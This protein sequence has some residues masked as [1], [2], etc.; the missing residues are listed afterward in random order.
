MSYLQIWFALLL[1]HLMQ[2]MALSHY[3]YCTIKEQEFYDHNE[4]KYILYFISNCPGSSNQIFLQYSA[5]LV[6][7]SAGDKNHPSF[8]IAVLGRIDKK[9]NVHSIKKKIWTR[10][11]GVFF[12][13]G[14]L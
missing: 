5:I 8:F 13:K 7:S 1:N 3:F 14:G 11:W 2:R 4:R 12:E 6:T 9:N 10:G